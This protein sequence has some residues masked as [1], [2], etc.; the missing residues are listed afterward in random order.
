MHRDHPLYSVERN[1]KSMRVERTKNTLGGNSIYGFLR[2]GDSEL[3]GVSFVASVE[4]R[5]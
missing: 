4:A 3:R 2:R 5:V 1:M